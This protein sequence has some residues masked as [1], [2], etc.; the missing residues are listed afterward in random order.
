MN[1]LTLLVGL[2]ISWALIRGAWKGAVGSVV[3]LYDIILHGIVTVISIFIAWKL[4]GHVSPWIRE[5]LVA[6]PLPVPAYDTNEWLRALQTIPILFRDFALLRFGLALLLIYFIVQK[7]LVMLL[8]WLLR[9]VKKRLQAKHAT[10]LAETAVPSAA[11]E[12]ATEGTASTDDH[13]GDTLDVRTGSHTP[14]TWR[15]RFVNATVGSFVGSLIGCWRALILITFVFVVLVI[16]PQAPFAAYI[17][18]SSL[19]QLGVSQII[20]PFSGDFIK[21]KVPIWTQELERQ[22]QD[23]L[24]QKYAIIDA[25]IPGDVALAAINITQRSVT[26]EQRARALYSW[27]GS[28]IAYDWDKVKMYEQRNIWKEQTPEE[29]FLT[30]EGVCIDYARLYAVMARAVG[31]QVKVVTGLGYDG[32]GGFGPHAWNEVMIDSGRWV[33]LD[34]TWHSSGKNWFNPPDFYRTHVV[35]ERL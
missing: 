6:L 21:T 5:L 33:P 22:W 13:V 25:D 16:Y 9:R 8:E 23:V 19:Y 27:I 20:E 4:A 24:N 34:A 15:K 11:A 26:D 14:R 32:R 1:G 2:M 7:P 28:R 30:R 12:S 18:Q 31:L 10:E 29:T 35:Q 17:Q 3:A